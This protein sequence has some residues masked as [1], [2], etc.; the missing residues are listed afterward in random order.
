MGQILHGSAQG[1]LPVQASGR[2]PR[3]P[4]ARLAKAPPARAPPAG[5][6][7]A[8]LCSQPRLPPGWGARAPGAGGRVW[9]GGGSRARPHAPS[10]SQQLGAESR[11]AGGNHSV[12]K[13]FTLQKTN[14]LGVRV[15]PWG[16]H[17]LNRSALVKAPLGTSPAEGRPL[18]A[19]AGS[20]SLRTGRPP[21]AEL[22]VARSWFSR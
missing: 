13:G 15:G 18:P 4:A 7:H 11:E 10:S 9:A 1:G 17:L 22:A 5:N 6:R 16:E 14:V 19:L 12:L 8:P 21:A 2:V 3:E 20:G